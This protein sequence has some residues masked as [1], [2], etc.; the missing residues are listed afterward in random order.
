M[1]GIHKI[2]Q[3]LILKTPVHE[4]QSLSNL[5]LIFNLILIC[6]KSN[7]WFLIWWVPQLWPLVLEQG[8]ELGVHICCPL[9][10]M[11]V[12]VITPWKG[13]EFLRDIALEPQNITQVLQVNVFQG[14]VYN[15]CESEGC[16]EAS[17]VYLDVLARADDCYSHSLEVFSGP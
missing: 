14:S 16:R 7:L 6:F 4:H 5:C 3:L 2:I 11:S 13:L 10:Q 17:W 1:V 8:K 12:E 15:R 9:L